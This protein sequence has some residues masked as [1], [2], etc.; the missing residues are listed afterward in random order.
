[1]RIILT[2]LGLVVLTLGMP[3]YSTTLPDGETYFCVDGGGSKT[4]MRVLDSSGNALSLIPRGCDAGVGP[5]RR[6]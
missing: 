3:L 5:R 2:V 4:E 6:Q 1:M